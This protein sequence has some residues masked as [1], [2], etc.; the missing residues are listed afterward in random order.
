[1]DIDNHNISDTPV[2]K[3]VGNDIVL[4][5]YESGK[6]KFANIAINRSK[7]SVTEIYVELIDYLLENNL[8]IANQFLFGTEEHEFQNRKNAE[9][10]FNKLNWPVTSIRQES[11]NGSYVWGTLISAISAD[12]LKPIFEKET[13]VGNYFE[14]EFAGYFFFGGLMPDTPEHSNVMQSKQSFKML[15]LTLNKVGMDIGNVAR[16]WFYLNNLLNWYDDFNGVRNDYFNDKGV[17]E[18]MIPASTGIGAGNLRSSSLIFAGYGLKEKQN[19]IKTEAVESPYQCPASDYKSS[20]SRAVEINHP[21][22]RHLI[23]SGTASITP[24]GETAN[25]GSIYKQIELTMK[26][27]K[28]ILQSRHM[29]WENVTRGIIY[30]KNKYDMNLFQN[31]CADNNIPELPLSIINADICRNDLLFEIEVDAITIYKHN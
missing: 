3:K 14:D 6:I 13:V 22:Y 5:E 18:R 31:F 21:N 25:V 19:S 17:F 20:F 9:K 7:K 28:G 30:F 27:V 26:V 16:T 2:I 10:Y 1:M 11:N 24:E 4:A 12:N 23:V 29:S 15:D 8:N